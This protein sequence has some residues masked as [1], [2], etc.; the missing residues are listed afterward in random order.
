MVRNDKL[1]LYF[2]GFGFWFPFVV[3]VVCLSFGDFI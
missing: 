1:V 2:P 3:V